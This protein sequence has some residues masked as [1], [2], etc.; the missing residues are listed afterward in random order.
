M[1]KTR[2]VIFEKYGGRCAYCGCELNDKWQVDHAVSKTNWFLLDPTDPTAVNHIDNL[3]PACKECNHYKRSLCVEGN[4]QHTGFRKYMSGFHLRLA[5]LPKKTMRKQSEKR[6]E[7]MQAI[8]DK[9]GI[10]PEKPFSGIFY[11]ETYKQSKQ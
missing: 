9:Y 6:K 1:S 8:A 10:T 2:R 3:N 5:K 7:Y 11:F 4:Y